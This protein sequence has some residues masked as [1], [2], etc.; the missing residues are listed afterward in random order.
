[1]KTGADT[2]RKSVRRLG[3][4]T[5]DILIFTKFS[6]FYKNLTILTQLFDTIKFETLT[7]I[8]HIVPKKLIF[9]C[10]SLKKRYHLS[11]W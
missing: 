7:V 1:M 10:F 9:P 11:T 8:S 6:C 3:I 2:M 4:S 5:F